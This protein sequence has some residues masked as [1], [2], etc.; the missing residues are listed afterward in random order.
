M[1][2]YEV[3]NWVC[4]YGIWDN[5]ANEFIGKPIESLSNATRIFN[6]MFSGIKIN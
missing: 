3:K 4:D 1:E 5:Q 6:W 2:R